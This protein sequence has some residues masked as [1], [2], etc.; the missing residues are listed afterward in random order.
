MLAGLAVVR[1]SSRI[2]GVSTMSKT[3]P[4]PAKREPTNARQ[5]AKPTAPK[6]ASAKPTK[7]SAVIA[8]LSRPE[9]ATI[10]AMTKATGWQAHS[11]RGFLSGTLKKKLGENV[12]SEKTDAGRVYRITETV[13]A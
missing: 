8:L 13:T 4:A 3:N 5:K 2:N 7:A 6:A 1:R 12:A 10:E 9:G 11:V